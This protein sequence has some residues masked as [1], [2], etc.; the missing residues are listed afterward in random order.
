MTRPSAPPRG[1]DAEHDDKPDAEEGAKGR[2]QG[3]L[4]VRVR[5]A[6]TLDD[7]DWNRDR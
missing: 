6:L 7:P 5:V 3:V 1:D 2:F 4:E